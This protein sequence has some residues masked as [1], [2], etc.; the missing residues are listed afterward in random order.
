MFILQHITKT[1]T[2]LSN[3]CQC[4]VTK[5]VPD[6]ASPEPNRLLLANK[7]EQD[8]GNTTKKG[9]KWGQGPREGSAQ[10]SL[11]AQTVNLGRGGEVGVYLRGA[12]A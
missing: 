10:T 11:R 5:H 2:Q 12:L 1:K 3:Y 8:V 6:P 7:P 4:S 9:R